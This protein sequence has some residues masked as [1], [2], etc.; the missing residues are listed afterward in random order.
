MQTY[1]K[2]QQEV[3]SEQSEMTSE[4]VKEM[5]NR[6]SEFLLELDN[7]RP[8]EHIWVDRGVVMSCEGA[9]HPNHRTFKRVR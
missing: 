1:K 2:R 4:Q 8:Q 7:L 6:Q 5:M 3:K 9:A